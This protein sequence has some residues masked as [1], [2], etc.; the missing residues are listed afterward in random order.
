VVIAARNPEAGAEVVRE[1]TASVNTPV[2]FTPTDVTPHA[3]YLALV[4]SIM[5]SFEGWTSS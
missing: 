5:D 3:D 4:S 2:R 1:I